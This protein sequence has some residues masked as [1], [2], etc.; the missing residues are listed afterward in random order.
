MEAPWDAKGQR[1]SS[2]RLCHHVKSQASC[3]Y[4]ICFVLLEISGCFEFSVVKWLALLVSWKLEFWRG[5]LLNPGC[6]FV[7]VLRVRW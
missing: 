3:F 5:V 1:C 6:E 4:I 2:V 7:L